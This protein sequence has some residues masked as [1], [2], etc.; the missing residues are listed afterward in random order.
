M[1][2]SLNISLS[3][4]RSLEIIENGT[5]RKLWYSFLFAFHSNSS[6]ILYHFRDKAIYWS[7]IAILSYLLHS[8]LP[9]GDPRRNIA[10][11]GGK[12]KL[13]WCGYT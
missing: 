5:I 10:K 11:T 2:E 9:L 3:H 6:P 4:S 12:K 8:T 13:E 1:L 7:K